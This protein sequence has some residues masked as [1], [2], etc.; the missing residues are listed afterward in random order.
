MGNEE[1]SYS[2]EFKA[3]VVLEAVSGESV[4][5]QEVAEKY[6]VSAAQILS[7]ARELDI[8]ESHLNKLKS[9]IGEITSDA[10]DADSDQIEIESSDELFLSEV[11]YG[12]TYD[13]LNYGRLTFWA[14]FGTGFVIL[15]VLALMAI[16]EN[17][18]RTVQQQVSE[19]SE[20]YQ[21]RDLN[22]RDQE[23]LSSFGI[24]DPEEG[25]YRIPIDSA[26]SRMVEE[27]DT[28]SGT[29]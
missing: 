11:E 10:D 22:E 7:W 6:D 1:K 17:S 19:T 15:A 26:I 9:S 28:E 12:V 29:E 18:V 27:E 2:R 23:I 8:S 3:K 25:I 21:V 16:Y 13:T 4:T 14:V 24:V 5:P 20:Y